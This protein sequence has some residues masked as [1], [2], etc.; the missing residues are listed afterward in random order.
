MESSA[1]DMFTAP[2]KT[3]KAFF[4][5]D[6]MS[7]HNAQLELIHDAIEPSNMQQKQ[8][9]RRLKASMKDVQQ[10][11]KTLAPLNSHHF[12][13]V[14]TSLGK[15]EQKKVQKRKAVEQPVDEP[16]RKRMQIGKLL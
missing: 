13:N 15:P 3:V 9:L 12:Y 14:A 6:N 1:A 5:P 8:Q 2:K 7:A 10:E 4:K 11:E 16:M